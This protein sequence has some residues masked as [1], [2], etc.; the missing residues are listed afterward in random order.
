LQIVHEA[1]TDRHQQEIAAR[2]A[3][4]VTGLL[5]GPVDR[6]RVLAGPTDRESGVVNRPHVNCRLRHLGAPFF[7]HLV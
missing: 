5:L 2:E 7:S 1:R 6:Q 4:A 3:V